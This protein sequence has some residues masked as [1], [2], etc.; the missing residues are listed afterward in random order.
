[1]YMQGLFAFILNHDSLQLYPWPLN[2]EA[3]V[4]ASHICYAMIFL[5][6][7]NPVWEMWSVTV[8]LTIGGE[9]EL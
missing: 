3:D 9:S 4:P 1:M 6:M 7:Y 5:A 8:M 2:W